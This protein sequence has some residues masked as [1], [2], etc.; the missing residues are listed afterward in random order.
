MIG[1]EF[2]ESK[3]TRAPL[4]RDKFQQIFNKTKEFGVLFGCGGYHFNV[5]SRH[6]FSKWFS[7]IFIDLNYFRF[8]A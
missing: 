3:E 8:C 4:S 2:V 7:Q 5:S 6:L 1:I